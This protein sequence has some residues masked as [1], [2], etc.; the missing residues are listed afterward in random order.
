L[1]LGL[2]DTLTR[3]P[4]RRLAPFAW[5]ASLRLLA[6]VDPTSRYFRFEASSSIIL[7]MPV[8]FTV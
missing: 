8:S 7:R 5:L 3:S 2:H 4:L 6:D 1:P